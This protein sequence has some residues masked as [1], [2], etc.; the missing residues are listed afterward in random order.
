MV[1]FNHFPK[2]S[3]FVETFPNTPDQYTSLDFSLIENL[4]RKEGQG[5]TLHLTCSPL[6][7]LRLKM[8]P[9]VN[10]SGDVDGVADRFIYDAARSS[11]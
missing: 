6:Q 9:F 2:L 11:E 1:C 4:A 8:S 7:I 5:L 10:D 3:C